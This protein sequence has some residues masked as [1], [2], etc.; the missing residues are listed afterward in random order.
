MSDAPPEKMARILI[1][2]KQ[3]LEDIKQAEKQLD[4]ALNADI[5]STNINVSTL[6]AKKNYISNREREWV[7]LK[8]LFEKCFP[9]WETVYDEAD[10]YLKRIEQLNAHLY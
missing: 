7:K 6:R 5:P 10:I 4:E 8:D 3:L 9:N 1:F 2:R